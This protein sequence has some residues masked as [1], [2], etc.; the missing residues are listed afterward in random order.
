MNYML[1]P[2]AQAYTYDEGYFYPGPGG[3]GRAAV[4]GAAGEPGRDQRVRPARIRRLIANNPIETPLAAGRDGHGLRHLGQAGR[5]R[6]D[7]EVSLASGRS[8]V[9]PPPR[10]PL[11]S[12]RA[13]RCCRASL[14]ASSTRSASIGEP[15]LRQRS[16]RCADVTLDDR[17]RRVHRPA[18]PL[19]LRQVD[20]AQLHRRAAARRPA[21]ASGSTSG[22]ST[23]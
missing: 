20:G 11:R 6:P 12:L 8:G 7:Q 10:Q 5:R 21:A 13:T 16:T 9:C 23:S 22:A 15:R 14:A 3:E 17:A 1:T 18:R 2:A 19:R 4:D